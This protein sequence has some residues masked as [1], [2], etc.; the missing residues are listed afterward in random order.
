MRDLFPGHFYKNDEDYSKLWQKCTFVFDAN[1]LL[2]FYRYSDPAREEFLKLLETVRDRI[3]LPHRA[4]EEYLANRINVIYDQKTHYNKTITSLKDLRKSLE[5]RRQHPFVEEDTLASFNKSFDRLIEELVQNEERHGARV[6]E[7][8]IQNAIGDLFSGRVGSP[9]C[10][11]ALTETIEEG[12]ERYKNK[13]PPGY[14]DVK[15]SSE[16]DVLKEKCKK[17]GDYIMWKQILGYAEDQKKDVVFVTDDLKEDW[18]LIHKGKTVGPRP[19]L[20]EE[21]LKKTKKKFY[22]YKSDRFLEHAKTNLNSHVSDDVMAEIRDLRN[23]EKHYSSV[24]INYKNHSFDMDKD[25]GNFTYK[26]LERLQYKDSELKKLLDF[27]LRKINNLYQH[28]DDTSYRDSYERLELDIQELEEE[29][30]KIADQKSL[31][32]KTIKIWSG[33]K[34]YAQGLHEQ[35]YLYSLLKD[36]SDEET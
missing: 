29:I 28:P 24:D 12:R 19:E 32:E 16:S 31:I 9:F 23:R 13:T 15:K 25:V 2:N 27:K 6:T 30:D 10:E 14:E 35:N 4:A 5:H 7:D 3:W 20:I 11:S 18:W 36:N 26:D 34:R 33:R 1:I 8:E 17:Y 22:M 21:F